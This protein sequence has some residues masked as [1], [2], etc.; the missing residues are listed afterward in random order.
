MDGNPDISYSV[1]SSPDGTF[2]AGLDEDMPLEA[3]LSRPVEIASYIWLNTTAFNQDFRPWE[4]FLTNPR[5][6]NRISNYKRL[7]M[8]L[9]V[10]FLVTGNGFHYGRMLVS[11][12]PKETSDGMTQI[13][14]NNNLDLIEASQR[15]MLQLDPTTSTGGTLSL[16]FYHEYDA[17]DVTSTD[18]INMGEINMRVI[19]QLEQA[20]GNTD[21][22]RIKV[23]AWAEDVHLSIPTV[24]N[25]HGIVA[26]SGK[27]N[28]NKSSKQDEYGD[29]IISRPASIVAKIS[30]ML[31]QAPFIG[32]YARA[33]SIA[34]GATANV[35]KMF[36]F[37]RPT[38]LEAIRFYKPT[39]MGDLAA[40]N[41]VD[42]S[43]RLALDAKQEVTIDSRTAGLGGDD[44]MPLKCIA[45]RESYLDTFVWLMS[46]LPGDELFDIR[47]TPRV[48]GTNGGA[49]P[50]YHMPA[51]CY[52]SVPFRLWRGTMRYRFQV[53][54]SAYHR[55][56]LRIVYDPSGSTLSP[57]YNVQY[58][59]I[60]DLGE[61]RDFTVDVGWGNN[62]GFLAMN[63][64]FTG[65]GYSKVRN[66]LA[67]TAQT[68]NGNITVYVMNDLTAPSATV[69]NIAINVFVSAGDD[70]EFADPSTEHLSN[71]SVFQTQSGTA[72]VD[73]VTSD[74]GVDMPDTD[75]DLKVTS[76]TDVVMAV[77]PDSMTES[78]L[79]FA[80]EVIPSIRT[81]VKRFDYW[82]FIPFESAG[83]RVYEITL[84]NYLPY[85]GF[86]AI[87][88][89]QAQN[90]SLAT[91]DYN[92]CNMSIMH[93]AL[94]AFKGY[95]GTM[96]Y[97]MLWESTDDQDRSGYF[98]VSRETPSSN[99][100]VNFTTQLDMTATVGDRARAW[101]GWTKFVGDGAAVTNKRVNP[102]LEYDLPYY[103]NRRF[104]NCKDVSQA[105]G[106][107]NSNYGFM[108]IV[109]TSDTRSAHTAGIHTYWAAGE[110]FQLFFYTGP[111]VVYDA[112]TIPPAVS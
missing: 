40:C 4:L 31:S 83:E 33:T 105:T 112:R 61:K 75:V 77:K 60:V 56:R 32:P 35:A 48:N 92:F 85:P 44:E 45:T 15:P 103:D 71:L 22:V 108:N 111:P 104:R 86:A 76:A 74:K 67:S 81:L 88:M 21:A 68:A 51:V 49:F 72:D 102:C 5:I 43:Q 106:S 78:L 8:K 63:P 65:T 16:P 46:D 18:C 96:R 12:L 1:V 52:A 9:N 98:S 87:G 79:V 94:M 54:A 66:T 42:T 30:G 64:I 82:R 38:Q 53:V 90:A 109:C 3:F 84:P 28:A 100:S 19:N 6:S 14:N 20:N 70:I 11:Y 26:Q 107:G 50:E 97:K 36:G 41:T 34:A 57:E 39:Y 93:W 80:G 69:A 7:R 25:A 37:S 73:K 58:S 2:G 13:R 55:G 89:D 59:A 47:V 23:L 110:D 27:T 95:R 17:F 99:Y 10:K 62:K 29:G 91:V 24:S 101:M